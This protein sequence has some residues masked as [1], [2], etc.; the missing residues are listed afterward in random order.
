MAKSTFISERVLRDVPQSLRR[1]LYAALGGRKEVVKRYAANVQSDLCARGEYELARE[2]DV[3][4]TDA[5]YVGCS[6]E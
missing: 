4:L 6:F 3:A 1:E 5:G 2:L